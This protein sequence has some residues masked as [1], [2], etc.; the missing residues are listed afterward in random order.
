MIIQNSFP[1]SWLLYPWVYEVL[2]ALISAS[3]QISLYHSRK[4][5]NKSGC[6]SSSLR[7]Y[8][9]KKAPHSYLYTNAALL[10][11]WNLWTECC[12]EFIRGMSTRKGL[13][14]IV[15]KLWD[16]LSLLWWVS[17][18]LVFSCCASAQCLQCPGMHL[19][20]LPEFGVPASRGPVSSP[21]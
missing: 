14:T 11:Q 13:H 15:S 17:S 7:S 19:Q 6:F 20:N 8:L 1:M 12:S 16:D 10:G 4:T 2:N 21:L 5:L 3:I 9:I 18:R